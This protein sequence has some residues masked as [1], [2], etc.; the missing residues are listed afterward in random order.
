MSGPAMVC[1]GVQEKPSALVGTRIIEMPLWRL[2]SGSVRA[3]SQIQ[4]AYATSEVHIF[5]PL[6]R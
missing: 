5:W 1:T 4:S 2:A 6:I 3:A